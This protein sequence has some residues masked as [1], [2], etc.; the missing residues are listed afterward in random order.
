M[1]KTWSDLGVSEKFVTRGYYLNTAGLVPLGLAIALV[2]AL[3]ADVV[4]ETPFLPVVLGLL[5]LYIAFG[6]LAM[7]VAHSGRP[8]WL[9]PHPFRA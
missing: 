5:T 6:L 2:G 1:A 8:S 4:D 9:V 3:Q 7:W